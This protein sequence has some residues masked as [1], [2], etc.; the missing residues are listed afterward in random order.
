M[1]SLTYKWILVIKYRIPMLY[2]TDLQ[3]LNKKEGPK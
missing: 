1:Y 3:K 2:A